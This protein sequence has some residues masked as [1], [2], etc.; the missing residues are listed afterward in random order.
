MFAGLARGATSLAAGT[1]ALMLAA[2]AALASNDPVAA[3]PGVADTMRVR[4]MGDAPVVVDG[5]AL[6]TAALRRFYEPRG[7]QPYWQLEGAGNVRPLVAALAAAGEHALDPQDYHL[8]LITQRQAADTLDRQAELELL[9]TDGFFRY[10][11]HQRQG[12]VRMEAVES[13]WLLRPTP[14]DPVALLERA[15]SGEAFRALLAELPPPQAEYKALMKALAHYRTLAKGPALPSVMPGPTLKPGMT[16]ERILG[17]RK[18]L[19]AEGDLPA[20]EATSTTFDAPLQAALRKFQ[21][22][23]GIETDGF[24]GPR[25]VL[26][27]NTS[28]LTRVEQIA[29][30]M[31]RMRS[32]P[33]DLPD[34]AIY[35]NV[36]AAE[37]E[38]RED[39][40]VAFATRAVV[41]A[42]GTPTPVLGARFSTMMLNPPWTV[43]QSISS[44]EILP[45][46]KRDP[47]YLA[48]QNMIILNREDD[49]QGL[50]ID[51]SLYSAN[52]FP[53][54]LRQLPGPRTALGY[55]M[56]NMPNSL[57][58]Y[59]HDTPD[60]RLFALGER[61]FSHGCVRVENPRQLALYLLRH[62]PNWTAQSLDETIAT[63]ITQPVSISRAMPVFLLYATV[64][65]R[66]DGS[67]S[68]RPDPYRRDHRLQ[69]ALHRLQ[70]RQ[71]M[72][73]PTRLATAL[74]FAP[75][76][77]AAA[78]PAKPPAAARVAPVTVGQN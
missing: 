18:R 19:I 10:A 74:T 38:V 53:F 50:G 75:P 65:T 30:N 4:L 67:V 27:M 7:W 24:V 26:T 63:G 48:K 76:G 37:L 77:T 47:M 56:F 23:Y 12:R 20:Q 59:L 33:R 17:I 60:R 49:P 42:P 44:R 16:D 61:Y 36:A 35:V 64:V 22:R 43:P 71:A 62:N 72:G 11:L 52:Y 14:V 66:P 40:K 5:Q 70:D 2:G 73:M 29:I 21:A 45:K 31:E 55:V 9:L 15:G 51:W 41:G 32:L 58:I 6:N 25:T 3:P 69:A 68:F 13:D 28:L 34:T 57:D 46:L 78:S 8:D 1:L 54:I 39:G